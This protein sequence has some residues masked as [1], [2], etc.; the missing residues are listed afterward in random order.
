M[1]DASALAAARA[2]AIS[3]L[4]PENSPTIPAVSIAPKPVHPKYFYFF[5][6]GPAPDFRLTRV[7]MTG[8]RWPISLKEK[9]AA[10]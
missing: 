7:G 8:S 10:N 5:S 6:F 2:A 3:R 9:A 4:A 1:K